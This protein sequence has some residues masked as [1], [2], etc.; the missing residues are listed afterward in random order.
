MLCLV[1]YLN[2]CQ[3]ITFLEVT[4]VVL[5]VLHAGFTMRIC[6]ALFGCGMIDGCEAS[7]KCIKLL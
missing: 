1:G 4:I 7:L 2:R 5:L 3:F 6:A